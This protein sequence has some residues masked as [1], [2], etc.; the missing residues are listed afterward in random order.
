MITSRW[1]GIIF[2][3]KYLYEHRE[4]NSETLIQNFPNEHAVKLKM[5]KV[6]LIDNIE[7][8]HD[9]DSGIEELLG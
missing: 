8:I 6:A 5:D 3:A 9:L 1:G 7:Q 4:E 2:I